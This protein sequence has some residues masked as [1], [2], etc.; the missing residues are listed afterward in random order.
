MLFVISTVLVVGH[1]P[2]NVV[3][4]LW[5]NLIMDVLAA[6]AFSTEAPEVELKSD[7]VTKKSTIIT[8]PMVR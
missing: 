8:Q 5:I 7:R 1:S 3:Q 2:F 4:L 6:I